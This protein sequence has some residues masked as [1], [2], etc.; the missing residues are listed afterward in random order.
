MGDESIVNFTVPR[1]QVRQ[2]RSYTRVGVVSN[3]YVVIGGGTAQDVAYLNQSPSPR[4]TRPNNI[5]APFWS[6]L[7]PGASGAVRVGSL[8]DGT[9]NV[10]R[11]RLRRGADLQPRA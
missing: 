6:D 2:R 3:G 11:R 9:T 8:T 7:N 1:V 10:A 4:P 5:V